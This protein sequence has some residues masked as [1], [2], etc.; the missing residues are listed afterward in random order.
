MEKGMEKAIEKGEAKRN[1]EIAR[2]MKADGVSF[3]IIEKYTGLV[4]SEIEKL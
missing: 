1:L 3:D 4:K 2:S